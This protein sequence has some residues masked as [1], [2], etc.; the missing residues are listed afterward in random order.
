MDKELTG[1]EAKLAWAQGKRVEA[2][3]RAQTTWLPVKPHSSYSG[4]WSADVLL[5]QS[6]IF[7]LAPEPPEV[8]TAEWAN[9]LPE[10]TKVRLRMGGW[11][12][13]RFTEKRNGVWSQWHRCSFT[14]CDGPD[15]G[16]ELYTEPPAKRYRP[17]S[18]EEVPLGAIIKAKGKAWRSLI[19]AVTQFGGIQIH[20]GCFDTGFALENLVH[21]I[22][23]GKT[24]LPCG[25]EA[26]A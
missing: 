9:S 17:W 14:P 15:T 5:D 1:D 12:A 6:F 19:V 18:L 21:S 10:G 20:D 16:W 11:T 4:Q 2:S 24:W 8:G 25:A 26:E 23:N 3:P 13:G 7:R 22:D